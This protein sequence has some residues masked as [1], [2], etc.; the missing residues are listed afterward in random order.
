MEFVKELRL[1]RSWGWVLYRTDYTSPNA[2]TNWTKLMDMWMIWVTDH[3]SND[4]PSFLTNKIM[5]QHHMTFIADNDLFS[6]A[7]FDTL[8]AHFRQ[9]VA[10]QDFTGL[11]IYEDDDEGKRGWPDSYMFMVADKEVLD[12]IEVQ[13]PNPRVWPRDVQPFVKAVDK[14]DPR[15]KHYDDPYPGWMKVS[16][17][18]PWHVYMNGMSLPRMRGLVPMAPEWF[19]ADKYPGDGY[20]IGYVD[21]PSSED[22]DESDIEEESDNEQA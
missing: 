6:G 15:E 10:R 12:E 2:D 22:P 11:N 16:L 20:G 1:K 18:S 7:S 8:R 21:E 9:W 4:G 17:L 14:D 13:N 5:Q 3:V 19:F